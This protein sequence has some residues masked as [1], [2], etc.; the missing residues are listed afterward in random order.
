MFNWVVKVV[1]QPPEST[2]VEEP[3]KTSAPVGIQP[4]AYIYHEH[5]ELMLIKM[6]E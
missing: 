5:K 1:P 3:V 6:N 4:V 2:G